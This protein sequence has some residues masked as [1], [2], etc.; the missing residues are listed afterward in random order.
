MCLHLCSQLERKPEGE[1]TL[2]RASIRAKEGQRPARTRMASCSALWG[3]LH[4]TCHIRCLMEVLG[5]WLF[6]TMADHATSDVSRY[7]GVACGLCAS[8]CARSGKECTKCDGSSETALWI[9]MIL[10]LAFSTVSLLAFAA[11]PMRTPKEAEETTAPRVMTKWSTTVSQL[12]FVRVI[13][14]T[15]THARTHARTR[16]HTRRQARTHG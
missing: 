14:T 8:G 12:H 6:L 13:W 7:S 3:T 2:S 5:S 4:V 15:G 10:L 1:T 9:L 11:W 16:M